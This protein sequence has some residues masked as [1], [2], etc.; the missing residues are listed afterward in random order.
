MEENNKIPWELIISKLEENISVSNE[1]LLAEWLSD[2]KNLNIYHEIQ[3]VW[4]TIQKR[5]GNYVPDSDYYWKELTRKLD[6]PSGR[7]PRRTLKIKKIY[8]A[9][10]C[11]AILLIGS[12]SFYFGSTWNN[13]HIQKQIYTN[14]NG[15]SQV[16]LPDGTSVWL[17]DN[18]TLSYTS[19]FQKR[20]RSVILKGKAFFEVTKD[21]RKKFI[22][23]TDGVNISVYGT[24]FS[25]ASQD[26]AE[27][28]EV[29]L[30]E[31]TVALSSNK[32]DSKE[33]FLQPGETGIY[34]KKNENVLIRKSTETDIAWTASTIQFSNRSLKEICDV[35]SQRYGINIHISATIGNKYIYTFKLH[36]ETISEILEL[37]ASINPFKYSYQQDG[38]IIISK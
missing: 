2:S 16:T 38:S 3:S 29:S 20:N 22:V 9:T 35:L 23:H 36:D 25:V 17:H 21:K 37:M 34:N 14:I 15:K 12:I 24:K 11:I 26:D 1:Q 5:S 6:L 10:A 13:D 18:S 7:S 33:H 32:K 8:Q 4:N 30:L 31:G 28:V 27:E 19:D